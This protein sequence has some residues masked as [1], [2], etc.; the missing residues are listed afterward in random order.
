MIQS[1]SHLLVWTGLVFYVSFVWRK[2]QAVERD[3]IQT[4]A[5]W[6]AGELR[7]PK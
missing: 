2:K 7:P 1:H 5:G 6:V 4:S 3:P